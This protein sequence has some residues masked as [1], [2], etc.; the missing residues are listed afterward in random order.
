MS[1]DV[2]AS[3]P[4]SQEGNEAFSRKGDMHPSGPGERGQKKKNDTEG[5]KQVAGGL[6]TLWSPWDLWINSP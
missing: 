1:T 5:Q 3:E 2:A 4:P 6:S